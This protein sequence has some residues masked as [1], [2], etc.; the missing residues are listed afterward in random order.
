MAINKF[1]VTHQRVCCASLSF[2]GPVKVLVQLN[3]VALSLSVPQFVAGLRG[4]QRD[5]IPPLLV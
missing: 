5:H 3:L 1:T 2:K 4:L